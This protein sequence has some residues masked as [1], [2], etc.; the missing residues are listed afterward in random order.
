MQ[1]VFN[2]KNEAVGLWDGATVVPIDAIREAMGLYLSGQ[3]KIQWPDFG[4]VY[5]LITEAEAKILGIEPGFRVSEA[6]KSSGLLA[7]DTLISIN[8]QTV[9]GSADL[10]NLLKKFHSGDTIKFSVRRNKNNLDA[11]LKV[12]ILK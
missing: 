8:G 5:E 2:A 12:G 10:E 9:D 6:Q 11:N 3:G 1:A 7:G 4:F